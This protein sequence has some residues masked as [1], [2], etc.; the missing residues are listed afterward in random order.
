MDPCA[1]LHRKLAGYKKKV[2]AVEGFLFARPSDVVAC[3]RS[4]PF[5]RKRDIAN[6]ES[7][8]STSKAFTR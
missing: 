5:N 6:L 1:T 3:T 7:S 2:N 8:C 4:V